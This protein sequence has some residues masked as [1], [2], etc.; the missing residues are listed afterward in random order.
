MGEEKGGNESDRL[1]TL[2]A[3]QKN[4]CDLARKSKPSWWG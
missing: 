4:I 1:K 3:Q 2:I